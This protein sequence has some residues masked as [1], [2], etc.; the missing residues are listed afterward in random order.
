[1]EKQWIWGKRK[2]WRRTKKREWRESCGWD[3]LNKRI[4]RKNK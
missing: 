2:G 4:H 3:V 1:M